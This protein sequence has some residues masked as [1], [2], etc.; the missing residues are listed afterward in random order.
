MSFLKR[1]AIE[2]SIIVFCVATLAIQKTKIMALEST[3]IKHGQ[4]VASQRWNNDTGLSAR[5]RRQTESPPEVESGLVAATE[6]MNELLEKTVYEKWVF[7]NAAAVKELVP[8]L[9]TL[10]ADEIAQLASVLTAHP[11]IEENGTLAHRLVRFLA[12][13]A[14]EEV[15]QLMLDQRSSFV[16][17]SLRVLCYKDPKAGLAFIERNQLN[18]EDKMTYLEDWAKLLLFKTD[19]ALGYELLEGRNSFAWGRY[20]L[21]SF[22]QEQKMGLAEFLGEQADSTLK[23]TL[24]KHLLSSY[25]G[26]DPVSHVLA[27]AERL[28]RSYE[29]PGPLIAE[30]LLDSNSLGNVSTRSDADAVVLALESAEPDQL[31]QVVDVITKGWI[32]SDLAGAADWI[33]SLERGEMQ[34]SAIEAYRRGLESLTEVERV[35]WGERLES[36]LEQ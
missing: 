35:Q 19:L 2:L 32:Q 31:T 14:P 25:A 30:L 4:E 8:Y 28:M 34:L 10:T 22:T 36:A 5:T 33:G 17:G 26:R 24:E 23:R 16:E 11:E 6:K 15:A 12:Y 18:E 9:S 7:K 20:A 13:L 27:S 1:H 21:S 3:L 29:D